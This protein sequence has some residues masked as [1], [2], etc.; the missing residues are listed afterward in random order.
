MTLVKNLVHRDKA[1]SFSYDNLVGNFKD[2]EVGQK[3]KLQI[4]Q[5]FM[6][7]NDPDKEFYDS[8]YSNNT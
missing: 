7:K 2:G 6:S 4:L 1:T 8:L 3:I 5:D